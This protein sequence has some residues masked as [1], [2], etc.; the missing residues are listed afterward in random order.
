MKEANK[1]AEI[2]PER[3]LTPDI[4]CFRLIDYA[5][6]TR[7][8]CIYLM[9][10]CMNMH[11][12]LLFFVRFCAGSTPWNSEQ[13]HTT[14]N[15]VKFPNYFHQ[16]LTMIKH[17][18]KCGGSCR[19]IFLETIFHIRGNCFQSFCIKFLSSFYMISLA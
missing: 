7:L 15:F 4:F 10:S 6:I 11:N 8:Q 3:P 16:L 19:R 1:Q 17:E 5:W 14:K 18:K 12:H 9:V 13:K 2:Y